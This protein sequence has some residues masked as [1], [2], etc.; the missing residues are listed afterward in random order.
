MF[1]DRCVVVHTDVKCV[2][3]C[4]CV[5]ARVCVK[6]LGQNGLLY[7][8][9][10]FTIIPAIAIALYSGDIDKVQS[11]DHCPTV[12]FTVHVCVYMC[13]VCYRPHN[14]TSGLTPCLWCTLCCHVSWV[15]SLCSPLCCALITTLP[16]PPPSSGSSRS[17][18]QLLSWQRYQCTAAI[19]ECGVCVCVELA[20]HLHW[21]GHWR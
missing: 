16:S 5:C 2:T 3:V 17:V 4:G 10:L 19:C 18:R 13:C 12:V 9:A 21:Y 14:I 11:H 20:G 15:S 8:N 7:Y 6:E 1:E